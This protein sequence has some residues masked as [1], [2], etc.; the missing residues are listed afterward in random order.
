[1]ERTSLQ[2]QKSQLYR[3]EKKPSATFMVD[4]ESTMVSIVLQY[5]FGTG[6]GAKSKDQR[7]RHS[8]KL[9]TE[10]PGYISDEQL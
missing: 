4:R 9:H 7:T 1:M 8:R 5:C 3:T 10:K 2:C 6:G